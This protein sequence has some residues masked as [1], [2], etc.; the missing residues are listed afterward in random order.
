MEIEF[1]PITAYDVLKQHNEEYKV[2]PGTAG[3]SIDCTGLTP[4]GI[5][6]ELVTNFRIKL[7]IGA[8]AG[9]AINGEIPG[10]HNPFSTYFLKI[11]NINYK[12]ASGLGCAK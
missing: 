5:K 3:D 7:T 12:S 6:C 1:Q 8:T 11:N 2:F 4:A 9:T 10:M